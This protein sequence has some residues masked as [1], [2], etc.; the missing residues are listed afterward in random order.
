[1]PRL[2]TVEEWTLIN[3]TA[4]AHPFHLHTNPQQVLQAQFLP[5]S[6]QTQ[7]RG[8]PNFQDV[9]NVPARDIH[10]NTPGMVKI[11]IEFKNFL[12]EIV[13]HCH[14]VDH[15]DMGMMALVNMIPE[16]PTYA[17]GANAGQ[18]PQVQVFNPVTAERVSRFLAFAPP[19][20]PARDSVGVF[21]PST[22]T[23]YLRNRN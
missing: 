19:A 5:P 9:I 16:K 21:D 18:A 12:G 20:A 13:Y 6:G 7:P 23:W 17:V 22:A 10:T 15:E 14:R 1:Q 11:R 4:E 8:R 3:P 2:N